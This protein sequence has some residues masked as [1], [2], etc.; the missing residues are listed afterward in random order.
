MFDYLRGDLVEASPTKA[1]VDVNNIGYAIHIPLSTYNKLPVIG[2]KITLYLFQVIREDAHTF[3]GF[4]TKDEREF[5]ISLCTVSGIG[6]KTALALIGHLDAQDL[7]MAIAQSQVSVLC[8]IPGVGKKTAERLVVEL[9]DRVK[10]PENKHFIAN[11]SREEKSAAGDA[12]SALIHLG[13]NALQA[14]KAVRAVLASKEAPPP[15]AEL[16]TLSL[17]QI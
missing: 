10:A 8:K 15:L 12:V 1:V 7:Y 4:T 17:R 2:S 6:P 5:F 3:Y 14:Q 9:R 13:Y 16:I 11:G